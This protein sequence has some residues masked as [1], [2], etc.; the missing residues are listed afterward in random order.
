M[1]RDEAMTKLL[2]LGELSFED[3]IVYCG[4]PFDEVRAVLGRHVQ[5]G[6]VTRIQ[7]G[8]GYSYRLRSDIPKV[9]FEKETAHAA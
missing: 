8:R 5:A 7:R 6:R 3:L 4:W 2:A 1:T 9:P